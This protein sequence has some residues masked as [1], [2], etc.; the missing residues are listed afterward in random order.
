[1]VLLAILVLSIPL[2]AQAQDTDPGEASPTAAAEGAASPVPERPDGDDRGGS[3][4]DRTPDGDGDRDRPGKLEDGGRAEDEGRADER[5]SDPEPDTSVAPHATAPEA[6]PSDSPEASDAPEAPRPREPEPE[7]VPSIPAEASAAPTPTDTSP[8]ERRRRTR[9]AAAVADTRPDIVVVMVDDFGYIPDDRVLRRLPNIRKTWIEGGM[10]FTQM[11]TQTPLCCPARA[12]FLTGRS[13]LAHGVTSNTDGDRLDPTGT[14]AVALDD[15]GYHTVF[16]GKYLNGYTGSR[17]MVGWDRVAFSES[18][19]QARFTVQGRS[20]SY[21]PRDHDG[22]VRHIAVGRFRK[23]PTDA[24]LFAWV[25]LRA[26]HAQRGTCAK[27]RWL[28]GVIQRDR[29]SPTCAGIRRYKPPSYRLAGV[30]PS[31]MLKM[32]DWP[33]GWPMRPVCESLLI[34]DRLVRRLVSVRSER[35][36]PAWFLFLSDNGMSWG[37]KGYPTKL[38]PT[39]TRLPFYMAGPGVVRG[40]S[41]PALVSNLDIASTIAE[42]AG[43]SMAAAEGRSLLPLTTDPDGPGHQAILELMP[44]NASISSDFFGWE[45]IRTPEWRFI[46]WETGRRELFDLVAD[47]WEMRDLHD[48]RPGV[49]SDLEARLD[50]ML[51]ASSGHP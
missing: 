39:S 11:Y 38:V 50:E 19:T 46:R 8:N 33:R 30:G 35:G 49:A 9:Q 36:R 17:R 6:E 5:K 13:T 27:C 15:A 34:V 21:A 28:S 2:V 22:A 7:P 37:Q 4:A 29:H 31:A 1:L 16:V 41:T 40:A 18:R 3:G 20:V 47:P 25:S 10:R 24:P 26:P 44:R 48:E 43:A 51:E 23:A 32:P 45:A 14:I 42:I 12:T